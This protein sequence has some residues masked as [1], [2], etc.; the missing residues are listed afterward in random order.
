[1]EETGKGNGS[2]GATETTG[3]DGTSSETSKSPSTKPSEPSKA[4]SAQSGNE[5]KGSPA[6]VAPAPASVPAV[7]AVPVTSGGTRG[8]GS[9]KGAASEVGAQAATRPASSK[10][11]ESPV[12]TSGTDAAAAMSLGQA[13]EPDEGAPPESDHFLAI[14]AYAVALLAIGLAAFSLD[15]LRRERKPVQVT[16]VRLSDVQ[17]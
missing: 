13:D 1:M 15:Y 6:A 10:P 11:A 2:A 3:S 14:I 5:Q 9:G 7:A 4:S 16:G 8:S 17:R 12:P